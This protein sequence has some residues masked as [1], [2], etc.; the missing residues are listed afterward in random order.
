MTTELKL[1]EGTIT[2]MVKNIDRNRTPEEATKATG[3][4]ECLN[5]EVVREMPMGEGEE[6]QVFLIPFNKSLTPDLLEQEVDQLDVELVDPN[7]QCAL[8]EQDPALADNYPNATQWRDKNGKA[9]CALFGRW[10]GGREIYVSQ[11]NGK[12]GVQWFFVCVRK[13]STQVLES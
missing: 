11:R 2:K 1:P 6:K 3:R 7:T 12:W 10:D 4:L 13:E 5:E 9:C 8:N